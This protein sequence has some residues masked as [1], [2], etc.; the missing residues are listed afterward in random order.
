[1]VIYSNS[2]I[3]RISF[4]IK[5]KETSIKAKNRVIKWNNIN[6]FYNDIVLLLV[7]SPPIGIYVS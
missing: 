3:F 6:V 2:Q 5:T 1:M 4:P 7:Y